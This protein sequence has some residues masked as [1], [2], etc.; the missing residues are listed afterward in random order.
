LIFF[1]VVVVHLIH[2]L[3]LHVHTDRVAV[4]VVLHLLLHAAS[5]TARFLDWGQFCGVDSSG[6]HGA[7]SEAGHN[8]ERVFSEF[9]VSVEVVQALVVRA[10]LAAGLRSGQGENVRIVRA[11]FLGSVLQIA[12]HKF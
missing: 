4:H 3:H 12:R 11:R 9:N 5:L 2:L 7:A 8:G 10:V 1:V 6:S